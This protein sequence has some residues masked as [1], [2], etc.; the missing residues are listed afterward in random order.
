MTYLIIKTGYEGI[1]ELCWLGEDQEQAIAK[2]KELREK[3]VTDFK[4]LFK[5][6]PDML[7]E[8]RLQNEA[9]FIC[10]QEWNGVGFNCVCSRL[11]V[12]PSKP[13]LR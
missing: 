6:D 10:V 8:E 3:V 9:D 5:D 7:N 4:E 13:M 2:V 1:E 12:S 11:R